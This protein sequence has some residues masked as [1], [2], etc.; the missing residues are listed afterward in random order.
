MSSGAAIRRN[1]RQTATDAAAPESAPANQK[2]AHSP[3]TS[4]HTKTQQHSGAANSL[5]LAKPQVTSSFTQRILQSMTLNY[6][7][8]SS[9]STASKA[10]Q[11]S[12][13]TPPV[14]LADVS[15]PRV[16]SVQAAVGHV[17]QLSRG[18]SSASA[19]PLPL[20]PVKSTSNQAPTQ[21]S[22]PTT[23]AHSRPSL[24]AGLLLGS[25]PS[26]AARAS[27][28]SVFASSSMASPNRSTTPI[29]RSVFPPVSPLKALLADVRST[30]DRLTGRTLGAAASS[31]TT[32]ESHQVCATTA[33]SQ[34]PTYLSLSDDDESSEDLDEEDLFTFNENAMDRKAVDKLQ[35]DQSGVGGRPR[36]V[37]TRGAIRSVLVRA[38]S[39]DSK[40]APATTQSNQTAG[41]IRPST[42]RQPRR[43]AANLSESSETEPES[44]S[45][46]D[47]SEDS[48][49][50]ARGRATPTRRK[51]QSAQDTPTNSRRQSNDIKAKLTPKVVKPSKAAAPRKSPIV[52][53]HKG[54]SRE[55]A[56][57]DRRSIASSESEGESEYEVESESYTESDSDSESFEDSELS[58]LSELSDH[59]DATT[60]SLL[61]SRA[62]ALAEKMAEMMERQDA[63]QSRSKS[64]DKSS[65]NARNSEG[66]D[67]EIEAEDYRE[68]EEQ[69]EVTYVRSA[70]RKQVEGTAD[71]RRLALQSILKLREER[72][73]GVAS[74]MTKWSPQALAD[75]LESEL[76]SLE[77]NALMW[78][79]ANRD[80]AP[81]S[82]NEVN[83]LS[84]MILDDG[85]GDV[86]QAQVEDSS[87][88]VQRS[89]MMRFRTTS[90]VHFPMPAPYPGSS[91]VSAV[92]EF[93]PS[94]QVK[95]LDAST[96]FMETYPHEP[97]S[98]VALRQAA[99]ELASRQIAAD[100][101]KLLNGSVRRLLTDLVEFVA[102]KLRSIQATSGSSTETTHVAVVCGGQD[103]Q[104][105]TVLFS[106]LK[107]FFNEQ[108]R[109]KLIP[110]RL[111]SNALTSV[112]KALCMIGLQLM[113]SYLPPLAL[114]AAAVRFIVLNPES[115]KLIWHPKARQQAAKIFMT[116]LRRDPNLEVD[117]TAVY[118]PGITD[119]STGEPEFMSLSL[120]P[121][122]LGRLA[123]ELGITPADVNR[124]GV[125]PLKSLADRIK[126]RREVGAESDENSPQPQDEYDFEEAELVNRLI[127]SLDYDPDDEEYDILV[128]ISKRNLEMNNESAARSKEDAVL[129]DPE[130]FA[131]QWPIVPSY[132]R[133]LAVH[134]AQ[135]ILCLESVANVAEFNES[136][137]TQSQKQGKLAFSARTQA[138]IN[139]LRNWIE[140]MREGNRSQTSCVMPVILIE[141]AE[142][143]SSDILSDLLGYLCDS[144]SAISLNPANYGT[145]PVVPFQV[146]LGMPGSSSSLHRIVRSDVV[147]RLGSVRV[148]T[149]TELGESVADTIRTQS[150]G[151][152]PRASD[153]LSSALVFDH[154]LESLVVPSGLSSCTSTA[155]RPQT[156]PQSIEGHALLYL[157]EQFY[158]DDRNATIA[159]N[160]LRVSL[161]EHC[162][163][164]S[165]AFLSL[166]VPSDARFQMKQ[167]HQP[168]SD[169]SI[170][171]DDDV[172]KLIL[173]SAQVL[174][175]HRRGSITWAVVKFR[176]Q[177]SSQEAAPAAPTTPRRK[178]SCVTQQTP[179]KD[180]DMETVVRV[181]ISVG[182]WYDLPSVYP[183]LCP[184]QL[185]QMRQALPNSHAIAAMLSL[186]SLKPWLPAIYAKLQLNESLVASLSTMSWDPPSI[187]FIDEKILSNH[188]RYEQLCEILAR[189][190]RDVDIHR[191]HSGVALDLFLRMLRI[192][193]PS[194]TGNR[195]RLMWLAALQSGVTSANAAPAT[196][197]GTPSRTSSPHSPHVPTSPFTV[198]SSRTAT[199]LIHSTLDTTRHTGSFTSLHSGVTAEVRMPPIS[200]ALA[201]TFADFDL[202]EYPRISTAGADSLTSVKVIGQRAQEM[203]K[204]EVAQECQ[205]ILT[206]ILEGRLTSSEPNSSDAIL[207]CKMEDAS[208]V[209]LTDGPQ[210]S[211]SLS[212]IVS[213]PMHMLLKVLRGAAV[214]DML[215][216][217]LSW[218]EIVKTVVPESVPSVGFVGHHY[219]HLRKVLLL[220]IDGLLHEVKACIARRDELFAEYNASMAS[221]GGDKTKSP[222]SSSP[223]RTPRRGTP[224]EKSAKPDIESTLEQS[225]S[226][227][228]SPRR[229][230][231]AARQL[232]PSSSKERPPSASVNVPENPR[233]AMA[234]SRIV[235]RR[236]RILEMANR[237]QEIEA[238]PRAAIARWLLRVYAQIWCPLANMPL[239]E[240]YVACHRPQDLVLLTRRVSAQ[241]R[242]DFAGA[243]QNPQ[244]YMPLIEDA[245]NA[246]EVVAPGKVLPILPSPCAHYEDDNGGG[247]VPSLLQ[248]VLARSTNLQSG[249][250]AYFRI[251]K[252]PSPEPDAHGDPIPHAVALSQST[253]FT[254]PESDIPRAWRILRNTSSRIV[255][256]AQWYIAFCHELN[257]EEPMASLDEAQ[258]GQKRKRQR[259]NTHRADSETLLSLDGEVDAGDVETKRI[260][261]GH[262]AKPWRYLASNPD[263]Q[264]R[265]ELAAGSLIYMGI[266]RPLL[267]R[268][269]IE[270]VIKTSNVVF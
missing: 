258:I 86:E 270:Y 22:H 187:R 4:P 259:S 244:F 242:Y 103:F 122:E 54:R 210:S 261:H 181:P 75:E 176:S 141:A 241:S 164:T 34:L 125:D 221:L 193:S 60:Q 245:G 36:S 19:S 45:S 200:M 95:F 188:S 154:M 23:P 195:S 132:I 94:A 138:G 77:S 183:K 97:D 216:L 226:S 198:R 179:S 255:S 251:L 228:T 128:E 215:R 35:T 230:P 127:S 231:A 153:L 266:V 80:R 137:V 185:A 203:L 18:N 190:A 5:A 109:Q 145:N 20:S 63:N 173:M 47:Y 38:S 174:A 267:R 101:F 26:S 40:P 170:N 99:F 257:E 158:T 264:A 253:I 67:A 11:D 105:R 222:Y 112:S 70:L 66:D 9:T 116:A 199:S 55:D 148:F 62:R 76:L 147:N 114:A 69:H 43:K 1:R 217:L 204:L 139:A 232:M 248:L 218:K 33:K 6:G 205:K 249:R 140:L 169:P 30:E 214:T 17:P 250:K 49:H 268:R 129:L 65:R 3:V 113:Q 21:T 131:S 136:A 161:L 92:K 72:S 2:P 209:S 44:S 93:L 220:E 171:P 156:L 48:D 168:D 81:D 159:A 182:S 74:D 88:K 163:R 223:A 15:A 201:E 265:F 61:K 32:T 123:C 175:Q 144:Q 165:F 135:R 104:R 235:S 233:V 238:G 82:G 178:K 246:N 84:G 269:G 166:P 243:L 56:A 28:A 213:K 71:H 89:Q 13:A 236:A 172:G 260:K 191:S 146:V 85:E 155:W 108:H 14:N 53:P 7:F 134:E 10:S 102:W 90:Q 133:Y 96:G 142:R 111:S 87:K 98:H 120:S 211:V 29:P 12:S 229:V 189:F 208:N 239:S 192:A 149:L 107:A 143:V 24:T 64:V 126:K 167:E 73:F 177:R 207:E 254:R 234:G 117:W 151:S 91:F 162:R 124:F 78:H 37:R 157:I 110:I 225:I 31:T 68:K 41:A 42:K 184:G 202:L 25:A 224:K 106:H 152:H 206:G 194:A 160:T 79:R 8:M 39:Q 51:S 237:V 180:K 121:K 262:A 247:A 83:Q 212:P 150:N 186:P 197:T 263:W 57:S 27:L 219:T 16:G 252:S 52:S 240:P 118:N 196:I 130:S 227:Q 256:I 46:E 115:G 59:V 58:E 119:E 50:K 100:E